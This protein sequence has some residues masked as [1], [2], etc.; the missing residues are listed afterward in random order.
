MSGEMEIATQTL[1]RRLSGMQLSPNEPGY[2]VGAIS[3]C[4]EE[5]MR[6]VGSDDVGEVVAHGVDEGLLTRAQA[7]SV[8]NVA[9]WS[10]SDNGAALQRTLNLW[11]SRGENLTRVWLAIHHD[12]F[13]MMTKSEMIAALE[14]IAAK[15]PELRERSE[16]LVRQRTGA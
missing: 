9:T 15:F 12:V 8:L 6:I 13:P 14:Q 1:V 11:L 10:G 2:D 4:V 16:Y 3:D 7:S 5:L